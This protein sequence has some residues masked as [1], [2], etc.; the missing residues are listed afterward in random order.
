MYYFLIKE[1]IHIDENIVIDEYLNGSSTVKLGD[2]YGVRPSTIRN[3]LI[4]NNIKLRSNKVNSRKYQVN[5]NAFENIE[6]EEQAYW[7]GFLYADGFVTNH[8]SKKIGITLAERDKGHLCKFNSYLNSNYPIKTYV[9]TAG[10]AVGKNY[11][12]LM[13]TSE[14]M[15]D[16][17]VKYGVVEHK[18]YALEYP[19]FLPDNL[20][21]H[22]LRG[23]CDGDGCITHNGNSYAVKIMC[24]ESF[25]AKLIK[26][27]EQSIEGFYCSYKARKTDCETK[28]LNLFGKSAYQFINNTYSNN[29]ISLDR[30]NAIAIS[31]LEYFSRLY[32]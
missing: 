9:Q 23:Y 20:Q 17:L 4:R 10:Y 24:V 12:R 16:D 18:T 11:C 31:S 27:L 21:W 7:L 28:S 1:V 25:A 30:K 6:T 22:F 13:I 5:E 26:F 29:S 15:Y 8:N 14:K 32:Q 3:I 2:K 19:D